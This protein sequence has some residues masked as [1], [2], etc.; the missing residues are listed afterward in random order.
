MRIITVKEYCQFN[1]KE[2]EVYNAFINAE[3]FDCFELYEMV[4]KKPNLFRESFIRS[5]RVRNAHPYRREQYIKAVA[6]SRWESIN[7][8]KKLL[9]GEKAPLEFFED[10]V[11]DGINPKAHE[12]IMNYR[13][14]R[15]FHF[16][17]FLR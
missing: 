10:Y 9:P 14:N 16:Y 4:Q 6:L 8:M 13:D 17:A 2:K 5:S 11:I 3:Y 12:I 15:K 1:Q 7:Q